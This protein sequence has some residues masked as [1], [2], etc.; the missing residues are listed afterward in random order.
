M[1]ED[2]PTISSS[3]LTA[4]DVARHS[5]G[6]VRRGF[7]PHEVRS[8]LELVGRELQNWEQREQELRHELAD[9]EERARNPVLDEA[10]LTS[11]LGEQ[12]AQVLRH[13]HDEAA[14]IVAEAES[15]AASLV[16]EAQQR[17]NEVQVGAESQA[18]ARIAEIELAAGAVRQKAEEEAAALLGAARADGDALVARAREHGRTMID[19]AQE[20]RRR[21]LADMAQRRRALTLQIEQ[22]RAARD[23]LAAAVVTVRDQVDGIVADLSRA[24][25]RARSAAAKVGQRRVPDPSEAELLAEAEAA[26]AGLE[27]DAGLAS[28]GF[29]HDEGGESSE[30]LD[31]TARA[32]EADL[33]GPGGSGGP[34]EVAAP[35]DEDTAEVALAP[36]RSPAAGAGAGRGSTETGAAGLG[37]AES[38]AGESGAGESGAGES[39]AGEMANEAQSVEELFARLRAGQGHGVSSAATSR[40]GTELV[41]I[42][43]AQPA[44]PSG[45]VEETQVDDLAASAEPVRLPAP[46]DGL[47]PAA[48]ENV[49]SGGETEETADQ[50]LLARR[51][52]LLDPVTARLARRLK[53]ALQDDQNNLLDRLRAGNGQWSGDSLGAEDEQRAR[54]IEASI[55]LLREAVVA[56]I[57]F[58]LESA[59]SRPRKPPSVPDDKAAR[60]S[61]DALARTVVTLLRRRL[62]GSEGAPD[63]A[64]EAERVGAAYREWR[65]ERIERLVGDQALHAFSA[66]VLV[67]AKKIGGVR[68]VL[69]GGD[70]PCADCDDNALSGVL[71]PGEEF[72][73]GHF[74]P[75]AHP[76]CRCLVTPT[77]S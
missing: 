17:A 65:G 61:A 77:P 27:A 12:S 41:V 21:V 18:A 62:I 69:G 7:D 15:A 8:Y 55:E 36:P 32:P 35:V 22:F 51:A 70:D 63:S 9:A 75:P 50:R 29:A 46:A 6:T 31:S 40:S 66:G 37:A 67:A 13:A 34:P 72:P 42:H 26:V 39:G 54:Y 47:A 74:H 76:G 38:G 58:G 1:S 10:T 64:D 11:A 5:F 19:Q 68:W 44:A 2:R 57:T 59:G 52:E 24:D 33:P 60:A 16:H 48:P 45:A 3:R 4:V 53:R 25:D 71:A 56:G 30:E 49:A 23:A 14:R 43:D 20:A 28:I 73:T